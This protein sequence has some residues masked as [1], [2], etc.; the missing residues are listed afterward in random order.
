MTNKKIA[1]W[2]LN[3]CHE[4]QFKDHLTNSCGVTWTA[5]TENSESYLY[6]TGV[7][8]NLKLLVFN[9]HFSSIHQ[10]LKFQPDLLIFVGLCLSSSL[11]WGD[12]VATQQVILDLPTR[13]SHSGS[14]YFSV[15][16]PVGADAIWP[17]LKSTNIPVTSPRPLSL[18]QRQMKL[19]KFLFD[20]SARE[21]TPTGPEVRHYVQF[22]DDRDYVRSVIKQLRHGHTK[23]HLRPEERFKV[24]PC[25]E[26]SSWK[27]TPHG[28]AQVREW[29]ASG[30]NFDFPCAL[31]SHPCVHHQP[32]AWTSRLFCKGASPSLADHLDEMNKSFSSDPSAARKASSIVPDVPTRLIS[33]LQHFLTSA[34]HHPQRPSPS[35]FFV[36]GV[37]PL[38]NSKCDHLMSRFCLHSTCCYLTEFLSCQF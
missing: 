6:F 34:F 19:L 25:L 3:S 9:E 31:E 22:H 13:N 12:V 27:L 20:C 38:I 5:T 10:V 26:H 4:S 18:I 8:K 1:F 37:T 11:P 21:K 32:V 33:H 15:N 36:F 14:Q 17:S 29:I 28:D 24:L 35:I 2:F 30:V 16:T 23:F 7:L